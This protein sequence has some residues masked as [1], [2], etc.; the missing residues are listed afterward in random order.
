M[1]FDELIKKYNTQKDTFFYLDP[2]YYDFE[3]VYESWFTKKQHLL[4]RDT[5]M[6]IKW[7]F[8]LSYNDC[9]EIRELYKDFNISTS[10]PIEYTLGKDKFG[11]RKTV[12]ELYISNY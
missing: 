2:P 7:K 5:L 10:K 6:G 4:L 11:N 12:H 1:S 8:L 9:P 3:K